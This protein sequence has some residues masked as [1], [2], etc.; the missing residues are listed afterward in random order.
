MVSTGNDIAFSGTF[1]LVKRSIRSTS[2]S[3]L[4]E[5]VIENDFPRRSFPLIFEILGV[6]GNSSRY[7][8][9]V[10]AVLNKNVCFGSR[11]EEPKGRSRAND[12][13]DEIRCSQL[14]RTAYAFSTV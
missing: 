8:G 5:Q 2:P 6:D 12:S 1:G 9:R 10:I 7:E 13:H 11:N 4:M 14:K 3:Q